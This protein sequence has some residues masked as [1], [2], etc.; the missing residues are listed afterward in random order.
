M[1]VASERLEVMWEQLE[2]EEDIIFPFLYKSDRILITHDALFSPSVAMRLI[3]WCY[4][5]ACPVY[6]CGICIKPISASYA[7]FVFIAGDDCQKMAS[8]FRMN[9]FFDF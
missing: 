7:H 1:D 6:A 4:V 8:E 5:R 3:F 2:E 9:L